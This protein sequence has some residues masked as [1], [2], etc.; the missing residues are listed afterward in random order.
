MPKEEKENTGRLNEGV[1]EKIKA[2]VGSSITEKYKQEH[3]EI[4][5]LRDGEKIKIKPRR[6]NRNEKIR[7]GLDYACVRPGLDYACVTQLSSRD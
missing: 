3:G 1:T 2:R 6:Q 5:A 4:E 7:S